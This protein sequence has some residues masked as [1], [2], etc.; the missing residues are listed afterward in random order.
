MED[1]N[2]PSSRER[3]LAKTLITAA[4]LIAENLEA[5]DQTVDE[6]TDLLT[7][8]APLKTLLDDGLVRHCGFVDAKE[9]Q[10]ARRRRRAEYAFL[11]SQFE[12]EI[13][14]TRAQLLDQRDNQSNWSGTGSLQDA[15]WTLK[16]ILFQLKLAL[17]LHGLHL[18]LCIKVASNACQSL[19][20]CF[21]PATIIPIRA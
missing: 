18:P 1:P 17:V 14:L 12:R 8:Y 3:Q 15:N 6:P 4:K 19:R 10:R 13:R 5:R 20:R 11:L 2:A 21:P 9:R 16:Y 7:R